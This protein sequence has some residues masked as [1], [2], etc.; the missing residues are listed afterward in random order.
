MPGIIFAILF[1]TISTFAHAQFVNECDLM[2]E[3]EDKSWCYVDLA[4]GKK[5][6]A[7]CGGLSMWQSISQCIDYVAKVKT[8]TAKDCDDLG[9]FRHLCL[10]KL[11][12]T[13]AGAVWNKETVKKLE[14]CSQML[15]QYA[16]PSP[17]DYNQYD[18]DYPAKDEGSNVRREIIV[19]LRALKRSLHVAVQKVARD[20]VNENAQ[21]RGAMTV[22]I[23]EEYSGLYG[24]IME[25]CLGNATQANAKELLD[26]IAG[27]GLRF[28]F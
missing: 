2:E 8:L 21:A 14:P 19:R 25:T 1:I 9:E 5:S 11:G 7:P 16:A 13:Q 26:A 15:T 4:E 3:S 28:E 6:L 18:R 22:K 17:N 20:A 23:K 10:E 27:Q 12:F 24:K